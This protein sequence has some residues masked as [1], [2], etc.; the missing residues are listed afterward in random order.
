MEWCKA[1][2]AGLPQPDVVLFMDLTIEQ[3]SA[4]GGFGG[5]RYESTAFQRTV[6][7]RFQA[8]AADI[9]ATQPGLWLDVDASGSV[10]EVGARVRGLVDA[11]LAA[12]AGAPL[13]A[14]WEGSL[15]DA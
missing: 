13:R 3:S 8:L 15:L 7:A 11:R 5:E 6:R 14:L 2:D 1:P 10:E 4:R 12:A 9:A